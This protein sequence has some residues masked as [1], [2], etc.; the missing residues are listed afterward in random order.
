M[1]LVAFA[2]RLTRRSERSRADWKEEDIFSL[3]GDDDLVLVLSS[4]EVSGQVISVSIEDFG[5]CMDLGEEV[6]ASSLANILIG[7]HKGWS[8][9]MRERK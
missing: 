3:M 4:I 6:S 8:G 5:V 2:G 1:G 9:L 7:Q